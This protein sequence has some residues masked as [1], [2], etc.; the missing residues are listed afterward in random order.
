MDQYLYRCTIT[1]SGPQSVINSLLWV[2]V[3]ILT[4]RVLPE[5]HVWMAKWDHSK[6]LNG[7]WH[8]FLHP[9]LFVFRHCISKGFLAKFGCAVGVSKTLRSSWNSNCLLLVIWMSLTS[10]EVSTWVP[11]LSIQPKYTLFLHLKLF[12][13]QFIFLLWQLGTLVLK[14]DLN[15]S[16][17]VSNFWRVLA[18]VWAERQRHDATLCVAV[19]MASL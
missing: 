7:T 18:E 3:F 6:P 15:K 8:C 9:P 2:I 13:N 4:S 1:W 14:K 5:E 16:V 11:H 12:R 17:K 19:A 10:I